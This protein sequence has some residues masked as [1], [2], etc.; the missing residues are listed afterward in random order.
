MLYIEEENT[1]Y[2]VFDF[3]KGKKIIIYLEEVG[4]DLLI[5]GKPFGTHL[6]EQIFDENDNLISQKFKINPYKVDMSIVLIDEYD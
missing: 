2:E 3:H 1:L 4:K 5:V 6:L